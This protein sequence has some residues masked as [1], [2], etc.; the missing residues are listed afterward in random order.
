MCLAGKVP[1]GHVPNYL[2]VSLTL[3]K[4]GDPMNINPTAF[5]QIQGVLATER[6]IDKTAKRITGESS[7][8]KRQ[9]KW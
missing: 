5:R 7:S 8:L 6:S 3:R 2:C 1:L 4:Q 9:G